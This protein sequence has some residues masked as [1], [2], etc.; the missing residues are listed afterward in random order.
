MAPARSF[1]NVNRVSQRKNQ[2]F[3]AKRLGVS[4]DVSSLRYP[5]AVWLQGYLSAKAPYLSER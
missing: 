2:P 3:S 5:S 1:T 4:C